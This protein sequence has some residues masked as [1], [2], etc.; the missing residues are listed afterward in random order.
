MKIGLLFVTIQIAAGN[1]YCLLVTSPKC[2][3]NVKIDIVKRIA[4]RM[5]DSEN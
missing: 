4:R 5:N 1:D 2:R 3:A